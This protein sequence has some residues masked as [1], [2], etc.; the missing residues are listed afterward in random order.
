LDGSGLKNIRAMLLAMSN[1]Q[2]AVRKE[3]RGKRNEEREDLAAVL[4]ELAMMNG[5]FGS[6]RD[7]FGLIWLP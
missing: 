7:G 1:E 3:E 2:L 6:V 4:D 5:R